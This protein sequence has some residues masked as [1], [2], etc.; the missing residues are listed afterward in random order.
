LAPYLQLVK[1]KMRHIAFSTVKPK[2]SVLYTDCFMFVNLHTSSLV[3]VDP[4]YWKQRVGQT[5]C[6]RDRDVIGRKSQ[7]SGTC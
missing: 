6:D 1:V 3:V 7:E 4:K 5:L 2:I